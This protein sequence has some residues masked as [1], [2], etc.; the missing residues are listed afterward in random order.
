VKLEE[1]IQFFDI[2]AP[3][4]DAQHIRETTK[5]VAI[6]ICCGIPVVQNSQDGISRIACLE[7]GREIQEVGRQWVV[8]DWGR[9]GIKLLGLNAA[10]TVEAGR[11]MARSKVPNNLEEAAAPASLG[12]GVSRTYASLSDAE[13]DELIEAI[14]EGDSFARLRDENE[15]LRTALQAILDL[16]GNLK[17]F[18]ARHIAAAAL[19]RNP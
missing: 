3:T 19:E 8:S 17:Y 6:P 13:V 12:G 2:P 5:M 11:E 7:C 4:D 1:A 14:H 10:L 15:R 16:T 9:K 18:Y